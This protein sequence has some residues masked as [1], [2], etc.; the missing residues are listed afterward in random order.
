MK[1]LILIVLVLILPHLHFAQTANDISWSPELNSDKEK[2]PKKNQFFGATNQHFY[3]LKKTRKSK[4]LLLKYNYENVLL[5]EIDLSITRQGK[6]IKNFEMVQTSSGIFIVGISTN[7]RKKIFHHYYYEVEKS[8]PKDMRLLFS[9]PK[10]N[11]KVSNGFIDIDD[12]SRVVVSPN[13][14]YVVF[15]NVIGASRKQKRNVQQF[16]KLRVFNSNMKLQWQKIVRLPSDGENFFITDVNISNNGMVRLLAKKELKKAKDKKLNF[17]SKY[18]TYLHRITKEKNFKEIKVES[19]KGYIFDPKLVTVGDGTDFIFGTYHLS[20]KNP[21]EEHGFFLNKYSPNGEKEFAKIYPWNIEIHKEIE[22]KKNDG[23]AFTENHFVQDN[24]LT[25]ITQRKIGGQLSSVKKN[26]NWNY[27]LNSI[28]IPSFSFD[29]KLKWTRLIKRHYAAQVATGNK[30][31][32]LISILQKD[33]IYL[34]FDTSTSNE[35]G[36]IIGSNLISGATES[37]YTKLMNIDYEGEIELNQ[38]LYETNL[39][40]K[41]KIN[42]DN[43]QVLTNGKILFKSNLKGNSNYSFG[44]LNLE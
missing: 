21:T 7:K 40:S 23:F 43:A 44:I 31:N 29:G 20:E 5:E 27:N 24:S 15:T 42:S 34:V 36:E 12:Y 37:H 8:S 35:K 22:S 17:S 13:S 3:I 26:I 28:I 33:K 18:V 6:R 30:I 39:N 2:S 4:P 10:Y 19:K 1:K 38:I 14:N 32:S 41:F 9:T 25:F 16:L 11:F